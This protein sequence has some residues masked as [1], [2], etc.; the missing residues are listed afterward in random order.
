MDETARRAA[1]SQ[2]YALPGHLLWR[3]AAAVYV[4]LDRMLPGR[5]DIH[6]YAVLLGL[7]DVE[8]QTQS[9]LARMTSVSGTTLTSVAQ[10]LQRDGLVERV[11]NPEDRRSYSLTRTAEGRSFVRR[12][13]PRVRRLEERLTASYSP[14][15][16]DRLR[17]LLV[18][19]VGEQLDPRTP[20][21]L[22]E[23]TGFLIT[24][25][26]LRAHREFLVALEPL[27]IEPRHY[28]TLRA[29][30]VT[31]PA[32]Q[33]ELAGLLDVSP[34]TVV[35]I[36]DHLEG[37]GLVTRRRD[38]VDRRAYRLQLTDEAER[39]VAEADSLSTA[40]LADRIGGPRSRARSDL[41]RL[42]AQLLSSLDG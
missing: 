14:A 17:E 18:Q 1:L 29:L 8:P 3:A 33:G 25:A 41:V 26:H 11:R 5:T 20:A 2:L 42:L 24:R 9:S 19:V 28:G 6:A 23:S 37:R 35:A 10:T 21:A 38:P 32:T 16:A 13:A 12:W 7:A 4:E 27:G 39:V 22:L 30:Q 40:V 31:G 34:A 36:V 15:D